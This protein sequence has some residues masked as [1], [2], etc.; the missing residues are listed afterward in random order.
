MSTRNASISSSHTTRSLGRHCLPP[1]HRECSY[2]FQNRCF[3][4]KGDV[5]IHNAIKKNSTEA[6]EMYNKLYFVIEA[7]IDVVEA[8]RIVLDNLDNL[9][10]AEALQSQTYSS[11]RHR[12]RSQRLLED[13]LV[14]WN[15]YQLDKV[16]FEL[17]PELKYELVKVVN[18]WYNC[19]QKYGRDVSKNGRAL[20]TDVLSPQDS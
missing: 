7:R 16:S 5:R 6:K 18:S 3:C 13:I 19:S 15:G 11:Q 20:Y 1:G 12:Q 9:G 4:Y 10:L 8:R 14:S 2:Y 17:K